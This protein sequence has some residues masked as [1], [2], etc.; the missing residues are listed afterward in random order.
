M[1]KI[2]DYSFRQL[3]A[4]PNEHPV[5]LTES[6]MNPKVNREKMTQIMF[7]TFEVPGMY[8]NVQTLLS[9][10]GTGRT[11]G[12]VVNSGDGATTVVP[13]YECSTVY[14]AVE[15]LNLGG[16]DLTDYLTRLLLEKGNWIHS[17]SQRE[18]VRE[19][20]E[21]V[22]YVAKDYNEEN[23]LLRSP[24]GESYE[25]P[26]GQTIYLGE[27]LYKC[28]EALFNPSLIIPGTFYEGIHLTTYGSIMK[29]HE[30]MRN[31]LFRNIVLTGGSTMFPGLRERLENEIVKLVPETT[32]VK[33]VASPE[34][35]HLAWLGGSI[36]G[37][38]ETFKNIMIPKEDY[39]ENG[40]AL[41]HRKCF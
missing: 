23:H 3:K 15:K 26:D 1:E 4:S 39:D 38:M 13:I 37:E 10:Y 11:I 16:R 2:W 27:E 9:L 28:P 35:K 21:K 34:R 14:H 30:D 8:L 18:I 41:V 6:V 36:L 24:L 31:D 22:C 20:K 19:A 32:H 40:P 17:N 5:L 12:L 7:E 25:L 33:V 29:C